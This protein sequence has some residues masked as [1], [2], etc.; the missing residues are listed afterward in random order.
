MGINDSLAM[1]FALAIPS[2]II[3]Y[4]VLYDTSN[5]KSPVH[6]IGCG[7]SDFFGWMIIIRVK[8]SQDAV[9]NDTR[10][11]TPWNMV[12]TNIFVGLI[13]SWLM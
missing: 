12:N 8:A 6:A 2:S 3:M 11:F 1:V 5:R 4:D 7:I 13:A 9:G 10:Q